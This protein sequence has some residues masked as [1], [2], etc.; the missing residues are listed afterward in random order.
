LGFTDKR[1][2]GLAYFIIMVTIM[3]DLFFYYLFF[4]L[5]K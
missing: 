2:G 3:R 1:L 4:L 5:S